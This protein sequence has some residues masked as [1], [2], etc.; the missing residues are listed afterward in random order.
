MFVPWTVGAILVS[1]LKQDED[2]RAELTDF[3]IKFT[4]EGGVQLWRH[5]STK[6]DEG[7]E[8]GRAKCTTCSQKD[9]RKLNCFSRSVVYESVCMICHP[10][11]KKPKRGDPMVMPGEGTYTGET[12]RSVFER[13]G[14]H[15]EDLKSLNKESHMVKHWFLDH[16]GERD[17]PKF[18]FKIIGKYND[19]LTRQIKEAMRIQNRPGTENSKGE[20]GGG[21]IP[22]L[23]I[24]KSEYEAKM[25]R[26]KE[27][28]EAEEM[29]EKWK[30]F[31]KDVEQKRGVK[32]KRKQ[33]SLSH[34]AGNIA[35]KGRFEEN[36]TEATLFPAHYLEVG[37]P[38]LAIEYCPEKEVLQNRRGVVTPPP[39]ENIQTTIV[40]PAICYEKLLAIEC[41]TVSEEPAL[42]QDH[43]GTIN[44]KPE[45]IIL[46]WK[47]KKKD[48]GISSMKVLDLKAHFKSLLSSLESKNEIMGGR[49]QENLNSPK[50]KLE[51]VN[52]ENISSPNKKFKNARNFWVGREGAAKSEEEFETTEVTAN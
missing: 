21:R 18:D 25:D 48:G 31:L 39:S 40:Y 10:D 9:E 7:L 28:K 19:C 22:R 24:D 41:T 15:L 4:E 14:E 33:N 34:V 27:L 44:D 23:K 38:V 6:L 29:E 51:N 2:R 11:G 45:K 32:S 35:K 49:G 20:F 5:F 12:S 3:R 37:R 8:C 17:P 47:N 42:R 26:L 1:R 16:P 30:T 52:Q 43:G 46:K 13:A 50:R 36:T